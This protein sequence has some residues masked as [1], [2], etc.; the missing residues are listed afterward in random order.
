ML[1]LY[2]NIKLHRKKLGMTQDELAKKA[3]YTD[4]SSIAKIE[5]GMVDLSQSKIAQFAEIFGVSAG[6]LM[7]WEEVQKNNDTISDAVVRMRTDAE[8]LSVVEC[9]LS[10]DSEKIAS[11]KQLVSA[12]QK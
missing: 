8:F 11:V 5:S 10:L 12:F 9:L 3:G 1:K 6:E 7:G 2:Q 4:R